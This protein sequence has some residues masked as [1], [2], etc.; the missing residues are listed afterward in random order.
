MICEVLMI[1]LKIAFEKHVT[2]GGQESLFVKKL[3]VVCKTIECTFLVLEGAIIVYSLL[4]L[5]LHENWKDYEYIIAFLI[6]FLVFA[7]ALKIIVKIIVIKT[8]RVKEK[9]NYEQL[10]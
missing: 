6:S 10:I 5:A 4:Y 3:N 8:T 1:T 7:E 9:A 2:P